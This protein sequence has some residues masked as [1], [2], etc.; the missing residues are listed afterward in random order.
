[1]CVWRGGG[2]VGETCRYVDVYVQVYRCVNI[3]VCQ[4]IGNC[5][6]ECM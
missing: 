3:Y 2:G 5:K 6:Y 1:M 4:Y